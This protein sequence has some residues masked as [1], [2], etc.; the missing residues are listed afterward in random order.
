MP[1]VRVWIHAVWATKNRQPLLKDNIR[2]TVFDHIFQNGKKKGIHIDRVN[3]YVDH[4]HALFALGNDQTLSK[5]VQ[6]MKGE[7][8]FWINQ[9]HLSGQRFEW[10]DEYYGAS[11]SERDLD[12]L[13]C[14]IDNQEEHHRNKTFMEEYEELMKATGFLTPPMD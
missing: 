2:A 3:G 1:F 9:H 12:S 13:R 4:A 6:L 14:Y 10:Q 5:V 7:S 8:S 11:V